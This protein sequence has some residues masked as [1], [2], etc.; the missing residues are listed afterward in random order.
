MRDLGKYY[1]EYGPMNQ[2]TNQRVYRIE[3][4]NE[5]SVDDFITYWCDNNVSEWG[6]FTI[7]DETRGKTLCEINYENGKFS[8]SYTNMSFLNSIVSQATG[9]GG[10]GNSDF[11]LYIK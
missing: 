5:C 11:N 3:M 8:L 7:K 1:V 9:K 4:K 6:T 2:R 10:W